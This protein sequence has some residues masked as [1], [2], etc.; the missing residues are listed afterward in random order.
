MAERETQLVA[1]S[2]PPGSR[3]QALKQAGFRL[4]VP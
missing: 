4:S 1:D 2:G 3:E